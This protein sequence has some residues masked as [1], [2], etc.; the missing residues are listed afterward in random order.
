MKQLQDILSKD[1]LLGGT[2]II[3]DAEA[4]YCLRECEQRRLRGK[5]LSSEDKQTLI[6]EELNLATYSNCIISVSEKE[7]QQFIEYGYEQV[8]VL[9]H[10]LTPSP[11]PNS[12]HQ[13]STYSLCW[14]RI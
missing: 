13:R 1:N 12:F 7:R 11:T 8:S 14:G 3:Y 6:K 10:S 5:Q 2:K 4:L 9:G